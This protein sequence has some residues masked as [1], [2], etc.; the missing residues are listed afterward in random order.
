MI[1][2]ASAKRL[3]ERL[4]AAR[5]S[6]T[7]ISDMPPL[8]LATGWRIQ[9]ELARLLEP[10]LGLQC[11]WKLGA[12]N[13]GAMAFLGVDQPIVGRLFADRVWHDSISPEIAASA[14]LEAE[15]EVILRLG[16]DLR[17][18]SAWLGIELNRP[19]FD[20]PFALG[21]GAIVADNAASYG[22]L[23]QHELAT[24]A[25]DRPEAIEAILLV[26]GQEQCR[27]SASAVLD[28]PLSALEAL[29][30]LLAD[31]PRGLQPGDFVATGAMCR[32]EVLAPGAVPTVE[33]GRARVGSEGKGV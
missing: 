32:S 4:A 8:D 10:S 23:C 2:A 21:A 9:A 3:A 29:R 19:S 18:T 22:L 33:L 24:G 1:D 13:A 16:A 15:P 25:L 27:G 28:G 30:T 12:T 7:R 20:D 11:G 5:L 6:G 26:D 17:P 31:D 14:G